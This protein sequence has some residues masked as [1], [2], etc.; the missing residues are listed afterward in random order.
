[1]TR[2]SPGSATPPRRVSRL[3]AIARFEFEQQVRS[4]VFLTVVA[5]STALVAGASLTPQ[6][7]VAGLDS[8]SDAA[9]V[10]RLHL[11]WSLFFLFT[12]MAF[13]ADAVLKDDLTGFAPLVRSLDVGRSELTLGRFAGAFAAVALCYASVPLGSAVAQAASGR[14]PAGGWSAFA[15]AHLAAIGVFA[16]PDLYLGCALFFGLATAARS[17]MAAHLGAV[18]VLILYGLGHAAGGGAAGPVA[19]LVEPFGFGA[20]ARGDAG[21]TA[22]N[23]LL[24]LA[25]GTGA[26]ALAWA[27]PRPERDAPGRVGTDE[28]TRPPAPLPAPATP[29]FAPST[30]WLQ[31]GAR[32]RWEVGQVVRS[33]V[34]AVLLLMTGAAAGWSLWSAPAL[35]TPALLARLTDGVRL[36]PTVV[37]LFYAGELA[38]SEAEHRVAPLIASTATPSAALFLPKAAALAI[39]LIGLAVVTAAAAPAVQALRGAGDQIDVGR[40]LTDYVLPR[41]YDWILSACLALFLQAASPGK[42]AGWGWMVLFLLASLAMELH[43]WTGE[44]YRYG[45]RLDR[46]VSAGSG[47]SPAT[48]GPLLRLYWGAAAALLLAAA[49]ALWGRGLS[50]PLRSRTRA[51]RGQVRGWGLAVAGAAAALMVA[52]GWALA[53]AR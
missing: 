12:A 42:L 28:E 43:G 52:S 32:T 16:L 46:A 49:C 8:G 34:F 10:T 35:D 22:L 11:V 25:V 50:R 4:P 18:A 29:R 47:L 7:R 9:A 2:P 44:L 24:G 51:A 5:I 38:W 20:A 6:L 1:M 36:T 48:H 33:P 13:A 27:A 39:V 45:G 41:S 23:R 3:P 26:L 31:A 30:P 15:G 19:A 37:V 53:T 40:L 21:T 14:A 17:M